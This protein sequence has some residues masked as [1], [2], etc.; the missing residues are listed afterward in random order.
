VLVAGRIATEE[1]QELLET[2][3]PTSGSGRSSLC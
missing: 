1:K 3:N 2:I